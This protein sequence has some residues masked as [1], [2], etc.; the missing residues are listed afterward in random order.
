MPIK[1][2]TENLFTVND[3]FEVKL[4]CCLNQSLFNF[5]SRSF[6]NEFLKLTYVQQLCTRSSTLM[7]HQ[8][9]TNPISTRL[10]KSGV[11]L[12]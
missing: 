3:N 7:K 1:H 2:K 9:K 11:S 5:S 10:F 8:M 12:I 6:L 4:K